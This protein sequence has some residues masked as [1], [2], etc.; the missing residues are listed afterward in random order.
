M[1]CENCHIIQIIRITI[2]YNNLFY[3]FFF[4]EDTFHF[5][6]KDMNIEYRLKYLFENESFPG[7]F[8]NGNVVS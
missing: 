7:I 8:I 6:I 3:S 1:K 4:L 5:T 2:L